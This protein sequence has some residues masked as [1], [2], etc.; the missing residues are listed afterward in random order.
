MP[1]FRTFADNTI[2]ITAP[3]GRMIQEVEFTMT[4]EW[5]Q[6]GPVSADKGRMVCNGGDSDVT[7]ADKKVAKSFCCKTV[8][9]TVGH[10]TFDGTERGQFRFTAVDVTLTPEIDME[11]IFMEGMPMPSFEGNVVDLEKYPMGMANIQ[12]ALGVG[13]QKNPACEEPITIYWNV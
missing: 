9:L 5:Y 4:T 11:S 1:D 8:T 10:D 2:T 13:L 7:M 3:V 6:Y 12:I